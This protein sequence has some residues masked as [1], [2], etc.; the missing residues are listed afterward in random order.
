[1]QDFGTQGN[2]LRS[3]YIA[4]SYQYVADTRKKMNDGWKFNLWSQDKFGTCLARRD[5]CR[6]FLSR[7]AIYGFR[8]YKI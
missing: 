8:V 5:S 7:L 4:V 3:A 6:D 2:F 1:M